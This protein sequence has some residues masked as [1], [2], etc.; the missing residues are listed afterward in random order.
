ML[1]RYTV[2]MSFETQPEPAKRSQGYWRQVLL[3][4]LT[5]AIGV[6]IH[7][8][9][10]YSTDRA[11]GTF[12]SVPDLFMDRL[13]LVKFGVWGELYFAA[14]LLFFAWSFFRQRGHDL[15]RVLLL[16]GVF[17]ALRGVFLFFL[18]IG[19]PHGA[20]PLAERFTFYP[21]GTHA[22]FPGGHVGIL[23]IMSL[24]L[25]NRRTRMVMLLGTLLF[26]FGT[27]L[28]KTHYTADL[29][30]GMLLAYGIVAWGRRYIPWRRNDQPKLSG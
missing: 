30:G 22:Y 24:M 2:S 27:M 16:L 12:P 4:C 17:Y 20:A 9:A 29:L 25:A 6:T 26:G 18:P 21:Y 13:P 23:T 5:L 7:M 3:G 15:A 28:A 14:L 10:L 8:L 11:I 19:M 1:L